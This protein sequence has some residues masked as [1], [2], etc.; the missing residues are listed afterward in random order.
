MSL[1]AWIVLG[2]ALVITVAMPAMALLFWWAGYFD[3]VEE[4]KYRMMQEEE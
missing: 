3:N 4:A 2:T 1:G